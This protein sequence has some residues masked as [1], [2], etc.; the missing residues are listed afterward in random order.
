VEREVAVVAWHR[1]EEEGALE[2]GKCLNLA[3]EEEQYLADQLWVEMRWVEAALWEVAG[4]L[5]VEEHQ[6][7]QVPFAVV[8]VHSVELERLEI[9]AQFQEVVQV[10]YVLEV[11]LAR[12]SRC[13]LLWQL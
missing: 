11:L 2:V 5:V 8:V 9:S 7:H 1:R 3:A 4:C 13:R 12:I 10:D 6:W